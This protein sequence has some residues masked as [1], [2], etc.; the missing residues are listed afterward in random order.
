MPCQINTASL[1]QDKKVFVCGG[2][3]FKVYKFEYET[4]TELGKKM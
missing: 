3:D 4:G 1:H 2:E